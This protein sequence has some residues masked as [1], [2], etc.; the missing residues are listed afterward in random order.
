MLRN[1]SLFGLSDCSTS[2]FYSLSLSKYELEGGEQ[3]A[4]LFQE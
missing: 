3:M 2:I 4:F 1:D